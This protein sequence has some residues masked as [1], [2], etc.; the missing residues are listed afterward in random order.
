MQL[1]ER[2]CILSSATIV[3]ILSRLALRNVP[4]NN[5]LHLHL[6]FCHHSCFRKNA[7]IRLDQVSLDIRLLQKL[8]IARKTAN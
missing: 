5:A 2:L 6:G 8:G 4:P 1:L 3:R 7:A